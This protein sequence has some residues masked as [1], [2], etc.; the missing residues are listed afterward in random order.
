MSLLPS[1]SELKL[2]NKCS[3]PKP[4]TTCLV[5]CHHLTSIIFI[6]RVV[7]AR[8]IVYFNLPK[9]CLAVMDIQENKICRLYQSALNYDSWGH[10]MSS[11]LVHIVSCLHIFFLLCFAVCTSIIGSH[12][13]LCGAHWLYIECPSSSLV[14]NIMINL[15]FMK[16]V[17]RQYLAC[18]IKRNRKLLQLCSVLNW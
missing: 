4:V 17:T 16:V 5:C 9:P 1:T 14:L 15:N 18:I 11:S 6:L 13:V 3:T 12:C 8:G 2:S 10:R 7:Q